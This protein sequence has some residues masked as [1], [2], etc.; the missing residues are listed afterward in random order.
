MM[1]WIVFGIIVV[2]VVAVFLCM[3]LVIGADASESEEERLLDDIAQEKAIR[4]WLEEQQKSK[5]PKE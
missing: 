1:V 2:V 4:E 3:A 5:N